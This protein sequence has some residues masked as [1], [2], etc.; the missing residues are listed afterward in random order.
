MGISRVSTFFTM[1][2]VVAVAVALVGC[3]PPEPDADPPSGDAKV[4]ML[5]TAG[6]EKLA[7]AVFKALSLDE[8]QGPVDVE[9][10]ESLVVTVTQIAFDRS[11]NGENG[12]EVNGEDK[13]ESD[14]IVF[15]G[16]KDVEIMDL[17][18]VSELLSVAEVP[19]G[20]YTK[21]R[22]NIEN[23]RLK[24]WDEDEV[25]TDVQLTANGRLF[26]SE[27]FTLVENETNYIVLDFQGI[28]LV[29]TGQGRF[30]FTP[31]LRAEI[32]VDLDN[33]MAE[34]VITNLDP[35]A[36]WFTLVLDDESEIEVSYLNETEVLLSNGEKEEL[37]VSDLEEG[38]RVI[39][40]GTLWPDETM[41]AYV[42]WILEFPEVVEEGVIAD[43]DTDEETFNLLLSNESKEEEPAEPESVLVLYGAE[44]F[45]A[46]PEEP[47]EDLGVAILEDGLV[48]E[49]EGVLTPEDAVSASV[50]WILEFPENNG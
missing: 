45:V 25:R 1:L 34:G 22:L 21:I 32:R 11:D 6:E 24:F 48:V 15:T 31:Q 26:V 38:M 4:H 3:P 16:E 7:S 47:E 37:D 43:L 12:D 30:I 9:D 50:I 10:I 17:R 13:E 35:E 46:T 19:A 2:A 36:Q 18:G 42:I 39:V 14:V 41:T 27:S 49:V 28:H 23:P 5:L 33:A 8:K 44:T 40:D 29:E 20:D